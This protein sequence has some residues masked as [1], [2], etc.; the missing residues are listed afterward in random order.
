MSVALLAGLG[1]R[2][3]LVN[4]PV[5]VCSAKLILWHVVCWAHNWLQCS[6]A[7]ALQFSRMLDFFSSEKGVLK[8]STALR[9][10]RILIHYDW[11]AQSYGVHV[12]CIR[13]GSKLA[14]SNQP[15]SSP[16]HP[17]ILPIASTSVQNQRSS[18]TSS[19]SSFQ[20]LQKAPKFFSAPTKSTHIQVISNSI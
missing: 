3:L 1:G 4:C 2:A 10:N 15:C 18:P 16:P 7:L 5:P 17:I 19:S 9:R 6:C 14:P 12:C 13:L 8:Y 11:S 20:D